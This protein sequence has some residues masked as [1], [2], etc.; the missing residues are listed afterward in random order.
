M[1]YPRATENLC[2]DIQCNRSC[3]AILRP[4]GP[5]KPIRNLNLQSTITSQRV[6]VPIYSG[7]KV[8]RKT[9]TVCLNAL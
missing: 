7:V 4:N 5:T 1:L 9:T 2:G 3:S 8:E 6:I